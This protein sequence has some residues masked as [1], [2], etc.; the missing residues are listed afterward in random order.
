MGLFKKFSYERRLSAAAILGLL[1]VVLVAFVATYATLKVVRFAL[2]IRN[3]FTEKDSGSICQKNLYRIDEAFRAYDAY[4]G[5][6][7]PVWSHPANS[8]E[9]K[10]HS[11]RVL[12]LPFLG[13]KELYDKIRLDEPWDSEWN[14][15]FHSRCPS[16]YRCPRV[17]RS[18]KNEGKTSYVLFYGSNGLFRDDHSLSFADLTDGSSSI[19]GERS[20]LCY[21]IEQ[22]KLV[23]W[24]NPNGDVLLS[25]DVFVDKSSPDN[26]E[27]FVLKPKYRAPNHYGANE[28]V[29][30]FS[31]TNALT[32][33]G[34]RQFG[35]DF[36][37]YRFRREYFETTR[38]TRR[39][40]RLGDLSSFY[41]I[42]TNLSDACHSF[43]DELYLVGF[44]SEGVQVMG[45]ERIRYTVS[46]ERFEP[47]ER[48]FLEEQYRREREYYWDYL[49]LKASW[50]SRDGQANDVISEPLPE[51]NEIRIED[52]KTR[53]ITVPS[54]GEMRRYTFDMIEERRQKNPK[55]DAE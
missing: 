21:L 50:D 37:P 3:A 19:L 13:E 14:K 31:W 15:Q 5:C 44:T 26:M 34:V 39:A 45:K 11:W 35:E 23:D 53:R 10:L 49:R 1:G 17:A 47:D 22:T 2:N 32:T 25:D 16:V 12:L 48:R 4:W 46:R 28:A 30:F 36:E 7:P 40:E 33:S 8:P 41:R 20:E 27:N 43:P 52:D 38:W 6:L 9:T 54:T 18:S 42:K 29:G 24:M 51:P 55:K